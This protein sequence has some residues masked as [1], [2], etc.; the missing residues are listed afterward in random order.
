M[1]SASGIKPISTS[2][3]DAG[4]VKR[5]EDAVDDHPAVDRISRPI[6]GVNIGRAPLQRSGSIAGGEKIVTRI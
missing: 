1:E 5:V 6:F 4:R 3:F 2:G